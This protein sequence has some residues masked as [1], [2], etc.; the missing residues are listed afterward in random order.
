MDRWLYLHKKT[1]KKTGMVIMVIVALIYAILVW[2]TNRLFKK[3]YHDEGFKDVSCNEL[4]EYKGVQ[5][6]IKDFKALTSEQV[7]EQYGNPEE[8][9]YDMEGNKVPV[10][11]VEKEFT[12]VIIC[13][14]MKKLVEDPQFDMTDI[15]LCDSMTNGCIEPYFHNLLLGDDV[16]MMDDIAVGET[17]KNRVMGFC[18]SNTYM[19]KQYVKDPSKD[20]YFLA[21]PAYENN[22]R[23][24]R[25]RLN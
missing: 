15:L 20:K 25:I 7:I 13:Y 5:L 22:M 6:V 19:D 8:Y 16:I 4:F 23:P 1:I 21:F 12:Y 2:N 14:D 18:L 11:S 10:D 17:I 9:A 24:I 3:N